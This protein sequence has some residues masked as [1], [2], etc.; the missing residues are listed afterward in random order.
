M[1]VFPSKTSLR[2]VNGLY[3]L[4]LRFPCLSQESHCCAVLVSE[5]R[6]DP[7]I[8]EAAKAGMCLR[9]LRPRGSLEACP[10]SCDALLEAKSDEA[11]YK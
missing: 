3:A 2:D 9:G 11:S 5:E 4:P 10:P 6:D 1:S 8:V 7:I